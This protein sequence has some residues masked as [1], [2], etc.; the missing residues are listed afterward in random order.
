MKIVWTS[1]A[2]KSYNLIIDYLIQKWNLTIV[3]DFVLEVEKAM[4]LIYENPECFQ[5]W[6]ANMQ[7]RKGHV[8]ELV[9]FFYRVYEGEIVVHLFWGNYQS[10]KKLQKLLLNP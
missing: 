8:N 1:L 2:S 10:P 4:S 9:S 7:Y 3:K 6:E 5:R